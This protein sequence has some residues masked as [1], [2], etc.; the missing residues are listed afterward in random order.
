MRPFMILVAIVLMSHGTPAAAQSKPDP[1]AATTPGLASEKFP[2]KACLIQ[3]AEM[4]PKLPNMNIQNAEVIFSES[5]KSVVELVS[6]LARREPNAPWL[7]TLV[8]RGL[9]TD[10]ARAKIL[11]IAFANPQ[12]AA[13]AR[14]ELEKELLTTVENAKH[15]I[16][17]AV[18]LIRAGAIEAQYLF[19]CSTL[20]DLWVENLGLVE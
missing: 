14:A 13:P 15:R 18:I 1:A 20:K 9:V 11:G 5:A 10:S 2:R 6:I 16:G 19:V 17:I 7:R 8:E 4:L 12:S 3:A